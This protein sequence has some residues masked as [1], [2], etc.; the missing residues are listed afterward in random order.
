MSQLAVNS[1]DGPCDPMTR[2]EVLTGG[3]LCGAVRYE[4]RGQFLRVGH[5]HCSRCRRHSGTAMSTQGR[6]RRE[7][8]RLVQGLESIRNYRV[9]GHATKA[10]C[11]VCGS[12]LFGG[13]WPDGPEVSVRFGSLDGDPGIAPQFHT[14][15][16]AKAAWDEICDDLPQYPGPLPSKLR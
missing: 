7:L 9:E 5:C 1:S 13:D 14:F 4:V 8:F 15:V 2:E 12:S 10:F 16:G 3:C 11:E 6:V